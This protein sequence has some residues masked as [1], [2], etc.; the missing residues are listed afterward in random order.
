M[1]NIGVSVSTVLTEEKKSVAAVA[2]RELEEEECHQ[3]R[4]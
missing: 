1:K 3:M 4:I 2:E